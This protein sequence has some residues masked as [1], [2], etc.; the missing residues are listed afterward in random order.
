MIT[1]MTWNV[2]HRIHAENWGADIPARWPDEP[3]RI[4]AVSA[5]LAGRAEQVI[6]LQEVSGDQLAALRRA[7]PG[8]TVHALTYPRV[9]A[10]RNGASP[11]DDPREHLVL[12]VDGPARQVA[13]E[14]FEEDPGKGLLAVRTAGVLVIAVH[15]SSGERSARQLERLS[16]LAAASPEPVVL[17]GDFNTDRAAVLAGLGPAFT[18]ADLPPDA[19]PTRPRT[20]GTKSPFI[21]H[22]V[23]RGG[24]AGDAAVEDADGLS[25]HNLV[26]ARVTA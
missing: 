4:A 26:R 8:R 17:L 11:L 2:L 25:D 20:E 15:V 10:P 22:V 23:V 18:V 24:E 13:A 19:L 9:P 21:D 7:L 3:E 12:A 14:P 5:R 16:E 1:V 6:A